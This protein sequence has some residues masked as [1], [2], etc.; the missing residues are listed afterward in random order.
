MH[1]MENKYRNFYGIDFPFMVD[2]IFQQG[3]GQERAFSS[4]MINADVE[5]YDDNERQFIKQMDKSFTSSVM[6]TDSQSSGDQSIEVIDD[7]NTFFIP[8]ND[9]VKARRIGSNWHL[10]GF[11]D[12]SLTPDVSVW[13]S[14]W[15]QIQ[16][17]YFIDKVPNAANISTTTKSLFELS[18]LKG[19]WIGARLM[20][21]GDATDR[22]IVDIVN[23]NTRLE[24]R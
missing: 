10:S 1:H 3:P 17:R 20:H 22:M 5:T 15:G 19:P 23:T 6:Y 11:R 12:W 7:A 16:D 8:D 18:R 4:I 21:Q 24:V 2:I 9:T 14:N 13:S